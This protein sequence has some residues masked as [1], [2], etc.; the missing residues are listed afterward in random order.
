MNPHPLYYPSPSLARSH[1]SCAKHTTPVPLSST[2]HC[3][4]STIRWTFTFSAKEKD[5]ETGFSYFGSRYY[6]SDLSIWLSVDPMSDKYPSLSPY[7]YCANNP[8]KL[9]DPDGEDVEYNSFADRIIVGILKIFDGGFRK[10]FKELK[11]SKEEYVFNW[12]N[13][14]DNSFT[15]DGNKLFI[16]YSMADNGKSKNAGQTIFSNLRHETT[17]GI[18]FEYGEIGFSFRGLGYGIV[19][20]DGNYFEIKKWQPVAYDLTDEYEAHNN[21]NFGFRWNGGK[22]DSRNQ[23]TRANGEKRM[24]G[25]TNNPKYS[26]LTTEPLN[27][28][29]EQKIKTEY[30]YALPHRK[31]P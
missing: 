5:L 21:Q 11:K 10:Q 28:P 24:Q 7:V 8:V 12:N 3:S 14:G 20:R 29:N 30:Y 17:H 1:P 16:N 6:N 13:D 27:C 9:V 31:R 19:D 23:W 18:Q 26:G 2:D 25:L 4:L 15:T 22:D